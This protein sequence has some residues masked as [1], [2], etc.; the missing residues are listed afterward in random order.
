[1]EGNRRVVVTGLG[2]ISPIGNSV[3]EV[4]NNVLNGKSGVDKIEIFDTSTY[5]CKVAGQVKDFDYQDHYSKEHIAKAKKLD[6]FV[7]YARAATRQAL[8]DANLEITDENSERIGISL[9]TGIGGVHFHNKETINFYKKGNSRVNPYFIPGVI[10]NMGSGFVSIQEGLKGPN[11]SLQTACATGN[12]AISYGE[13]IIKSGKA[14]AMVV[15]ASESTIEPITIAG[16]DNMRALSSSFNDTPKTA[17]RPFDKNRDGFVISE[18]SAVLILEEYEYAKKRN[19]NILAE[20]ITVGMSGDAYD[21]V[22]PCSDGDGAYR[23]I[24]NALKEGKVDPDSIDYVNFH[25]TSTPLG[26]KGE[27]QAVLKAFS[28]GISKGSKL[29]LMGSTKSMTGHLIA[30]ASSLEALISILTIKHN[31][32]PPNINIFDLDEDLGLSFN[33]LNTE[34]VEKD[35]NYVLSNSFGFG[36]HNSSAIFGRV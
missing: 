25:G 22:M 29:P 26:D 31:K 17:S 11:V 32:V 3:D 35:V 34:V 5:R 24:S 19:A 20:L 9:G 6:N 36:G 21:M 8:A 23:S 30:A 18:G 16:F 33:E 27:S 15:G 1:M 12:H 13:L 7:H 4:W 2:V 28:K 14:D 10:G